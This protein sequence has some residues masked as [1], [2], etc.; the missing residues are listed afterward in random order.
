M[1]PTYYHEGAERSARVRQL[2][3]KIARHYD[4]I[5]DLQSFGAHRAWKQHLLRVLAPSP[6]ERVL[7]LACGSGDLAFRLLESH[8]SARVVGGDYTLSML[9]VAQHRAARNLAHPE[10]W[11]Q[12]DG[13]AL[14]FRD[15]S[16]DA[17]MIAYGLRNM[18]HPA[19]A[20]SEMAR[21]LKSGGRLVILD[22]GKPS[23][24]AVR[25][26]YA[27]FLRIVQPALGYLFFGDSA[28]YRYIYESLLHYPAQKGVTK[29][30]SATGFLNIRCHDLA[31]GM[32]SL[33]IAVRATCFR[34]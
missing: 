12:L 34:K 5:N 27:I 24:P 22:F 25:A 17:I 21:V 30:L 15:A 29:L 23:N 31:L 20:L 10:G 1:N 26:L 19:R 18:A 14:P 3:E 33:H 9:R 7:D 32:M 16:F 28:T 13:L 8:P 6:N 2:F 11:I 4:L